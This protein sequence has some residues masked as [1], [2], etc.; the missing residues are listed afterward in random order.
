MRNNKEDLNKC[1]LELE[2]CRKVLKNATSPVERLMA[3]VDIDYYEE[4]LDELLDK[5]L[6]EERIC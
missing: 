4:M 3:K 5:V 6:E 1:L 2:A